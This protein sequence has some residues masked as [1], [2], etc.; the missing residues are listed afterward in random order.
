MHSGK[1]INIQKF[2]ENDLQTFCSKKEANDWLPL[3]QI[4]WKKH[5]GE[6]KKTWVSKISKFKLFIQFASFNY[7]VYFLHWNDWKSC[8]M[9]WCLFFH[10]WGEWKKSTNQLFKAKSQYGTKKFQMRWKS[11]QSI[12]L[13]YF[14]IEFGNF[15]FY[16]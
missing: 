6:Q 14:S 10:K 4:S 12:T 5:L 2:D 9:L 16:K 13:N 7:Y 11:N 8:S 1:L 15:F 3:L